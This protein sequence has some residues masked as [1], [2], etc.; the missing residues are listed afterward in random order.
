MVRTA[1]RWS[2]APQSRR[3]DH[4][5]LGRGER[6]AGRDAAARIS[7]K[8]SSHR[9]RRGCACD[10]RRTRTAE[11][12]GSQMA[13]V[14]DFGRR[15]IASASC[16]SSFGRIRTSRARRRDSRRGG[17]MRSTRKCRPHDLGVLTICSRKPADDGGHRHDRCDAMTRP[18]NV[19][20]ERSLLARSWSMAMRQP[21]A[22]NGVSSTPPERFDRIEPRRA[23]G[24]VDAEADP[25]KS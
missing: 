8:R 12:P 18:A 20:A 3:L 5:Q 2:A 19:S 7:M 1:G 23:M 4:R 15:A 22:P 11:R 21:R 16:G 17:E 6:A 24:R 14:V 25:T 10:F 9:T 13:A